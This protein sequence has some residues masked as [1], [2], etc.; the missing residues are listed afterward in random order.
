M[1]QTDYV[2]IIL[3]FYILFYNVKGALGEAG[4]D[5]GK[6][7]TKSCDI[8]TLQ[9]YCESSAC[10]QCYKNFSTSFY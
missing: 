6:C 2:L 10:D 9:K 3:R 4:E 1:Y 5:H 8:L 7:V